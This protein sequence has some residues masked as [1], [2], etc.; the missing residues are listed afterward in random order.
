DVRGAAGMPG[1]SSTIQVRPSLMPCSTRASR[2]ASSGQGRAHWSV[3]LHACSHF[4]AELIRS[5]IAGMSACSARRIVYV[6]VMA[7]R[8]NGRPALA[9]GDDPGQPPGMVGGDV[10]G[11][12][13]ANRAG[14]V[15][16]P[17]SLLAL[18]RPH[19][20]FLRTAGIVSRLLAGRHLAHLDPQ[21]VSVRRVDG[22]REPEPVALLVEANPVDLKDRDAPIGGE[23]YTTW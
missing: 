21:P 14:R 15:G 19:E 2:L 22:D 13:A 8:W 1:L 7:P 6:G 16:T 11:A 20:S 4:A 12:L 9:A 18:P 17:A 5:R 3:S 23:Q 10:E